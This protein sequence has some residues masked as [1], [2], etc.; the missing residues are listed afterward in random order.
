MM[1]GSSVCPICQVTDV[2]IRY[3]TI[4]HSASGFTLA[5]V[6]SGDGTGGTAK[7][8]ARYSIHDITVDDIDGTK[9]N[10]GGT[11][12]LILNTWR[13]NVLNS[14][15]VNHVT[16]VPNANNHLTSLQNS[17]SN[18]VM[19][20]FNFT[21]NLMMAGPYPVW[22]AGG[23]GSNCAVS[24]VPLISLGKCF[25]PYSFSNNAIIGSPAVF[26]ASK[27]PSG[28]YF[29]ADTGAVEF[30]NYNNGDGGDYHLLPSSPFKNKGTD[31]RDLGADIDALT[32]AIAGVE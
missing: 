12:F 32:N 25:V 2:T 22:T 11:I 16:A 21:N 19:S 8:G 17:L 13:A 27:W 24:N 14:V 30:V 23:G 29:P 20:G 7:A 1:N 31:G 26:P 18:P 5:T 6:L 15:T 10:G 4:S 3:S 9:Y 28:N